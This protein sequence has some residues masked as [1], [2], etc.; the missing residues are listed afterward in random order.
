MHK[1][2]KIRFPVATHRVCGR[3]NPGEAERKK[4]MMLERKQTR[5]DVELLCKY[6][7]YKNHK[8]MPGKMV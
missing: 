6:M 8:F 3:V 4:R 1:Q 5:S 7:L 2:P